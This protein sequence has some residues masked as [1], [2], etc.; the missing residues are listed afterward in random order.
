M[1][2][3]EL[4]ELEMEKKHPKRLDLGKNPGAERDM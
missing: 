1:E 3:L 4:S 2:K